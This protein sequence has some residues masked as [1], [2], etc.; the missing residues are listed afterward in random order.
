MVIANWLTSAWSPIVLHFFRLWFIISSTFLNIQYRIDINTAFEGKRHIL[1]VKS[2]GL[3]KLN[4]TQIWCNAYPQELTKVNIFSTIF[5]K[6]LVL[7]R[8]LQKVRIMFQS[9]VGVCWT[10]NPCLAVLRYW[11][12]QCKTYKSCAWYLSFLCN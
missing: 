2:F 12:E 3:K 11:S 5:L 1:R 4:T 10:S 9:Y 6:I 7:I 8:D